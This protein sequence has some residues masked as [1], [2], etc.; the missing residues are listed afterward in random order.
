RIQTDPNRL[1]QILLNLI[2]N[3]IKFTNT[4]GVRV[5]TSLDQAD[6]KKATLNFR[7]VDTGIGISAEKIGA[8]FV[9]FK[10]I[11]SSTTRRFGGTGLGL[12]IS[13][14]LAALLGG[15]LLVSS[16][17]G[18]GS[19]FMLTIPV[20]PIERIEWMAHPEDMIS[21]RSRPRQAVER[22]LNAKVLLAEDGID[23]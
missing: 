23:N 6:P 10:Q 7:V 17:S 15:T 9:P 19:E 18:S 1:R 8:L 14:R 4:G 22:T 11:D 13:S 16:E 5:V 20:G 21:D 3:A 12:A 2:S